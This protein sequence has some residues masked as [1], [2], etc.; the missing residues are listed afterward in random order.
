MR[1]K[2]LRQWNMPIGDESPSFVWKW[3]AVVADVFEKPRHH[4]FTR[5]PLS[6][7]SQV[8]QK[9]FFAQV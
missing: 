5:V 9:T 2:K 4:F 8:S 6:Q 1:H 3:T 7:Y